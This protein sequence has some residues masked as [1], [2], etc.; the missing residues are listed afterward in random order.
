MIAFILI[1][2]ALG[3]LYRKM[4]TQPETRGLLIMA[5]LVV[6]IG[7]VFYTQIEKW[8][9]LDAIYFC[10][11]TLGTVGYGDIVPKTDA[12]KIFTIFYIIFGLAVI[13][14]FF[15]SLGQFIHPGQLF[16]RGETVVAQA[17]GEI[18]DVVDRAEGDPGSEDGDTS[19]SKPHD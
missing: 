14:G 7:V 6:V 15:A 2:T 18:T 13:G 12:G 17:K 10:V 16:S 19:T 1:F 4:F 3:R 5:S 8:S 9:V 11:V